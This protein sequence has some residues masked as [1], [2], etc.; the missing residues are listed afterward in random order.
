MN[1]I[2]IGERQGHSTAIKPASTGHMEITAI[3]DREMFR[4]EAMKGVPVGS[5]A[6]SSTTTA[7]EPTTEYR[8]QVR[9]SAPLPDSGAI[10]AMISAN[11]PGGGSTPVRLKHI[12]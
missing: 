12:L 7:T 5:I 3:P 4:A 1:C 11:P 9:F 2:P 10:R 8:L 6:S